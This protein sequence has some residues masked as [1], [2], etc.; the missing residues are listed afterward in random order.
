MEDQSRVGLRV[1]NVVHMFS[2]LIKVLQEG[3]RSVWA[4]AQNTVIFYALT[5]MGQNSFLVSVYSKY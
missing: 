2:V 3:E 4:A 1:S 5:E